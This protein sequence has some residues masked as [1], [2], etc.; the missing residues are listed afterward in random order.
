MSLLGLDQ[1]V[2]TDERLVSP[3]DAGLATAGVPSW[4]PRVCLP[5]PTRQP[6]APNDQLNAGF[7]YPSGLMKNLATI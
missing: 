3:V 6:A 5:L 2:A 1:P 4:C 7:I